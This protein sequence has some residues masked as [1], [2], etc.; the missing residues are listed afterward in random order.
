MRGFVSSLLLWTVACYSQPGAEPLPCNT[1]D[2]CDD[3]LTCQAGNCMA[4]PATTTAST[5]SDP[6]T[7]G[8]TGTGDPTASETTGTGDGPCEPPD[9]ELDGQCVRALTFAT[10]VQQTFAESEVDHP[11]TA[12]ACLSVECPP[13]TT[14]IGGGYF[15]LG[16]ALTEA[17]A[18]PDGNAYQI[19]GDAVDGA[20]FNRWNVFAQC[21]AIEGDLLYEVSA[22]PEVVAADADDCRTANCP[23]GTVLLGGGGRWPAWFRVT[24]MR[25]GSGWRICGAA[26]GAEAQVEFHYTCGVLAPNAS[27][28][29][30]ESEATAM[31][32]ETQCATATCPP[33]DLVLGGGAGAGDGFEVLVSQREISPIDKSW[34]GCARASA[35][36]GG[37]VFATALC[38]QDP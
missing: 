34:R 6:S 2:D 4:P 8:D 5:G 3:G 10:V 28:F 7:A 12:D 20:M 13:Q 27:T 17:R 1:D 25:P 18:N 23:D 14:V 11:G 36:I 32:A 21:A 26:E 22:T 30:V 9:L 24:D 16:V 35:A 19:C 33:A 38:L 37:Q 31:P 29:V 15:T